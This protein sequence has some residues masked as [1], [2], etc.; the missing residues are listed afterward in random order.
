MKTCSPAT[1][2][3]TGEKRFLRPR[4]RVRAQLDLWNEKVGE[5][6]LFLSLLLAYW[7]AQAWFFVYGVKYELSLQL[8]ADWSRYTLIVG[9]G[10]GYVATFNALLLPITANRTLTNILYRLPLYDIFSVARWLPELHS[11]IAR[12]FTM[13][14][15]LHGIALSIAYGV[16]AIPFEGG[17]FS[18]SN[19]IPSTMVF[20][21]GC[22]LMAFL[23]A[24]V[25]LSLEAVRRRVYRVF[26]AS[27]MPLAIL[28][29]V[30]LIFHGLRG[31]RPWSAYFFGLPLILYIVD[32]VYHA[33]AAAFT[34][35]R[36]L[37]VRMSHENSNVV[38][39]EIERRGRKFVAG[40][41]FKLAWKSSLGARLSVA[42]EWHPFTVASSPSFDKDHMIFF[43]AATGSWT[44]ALR[45][46]ALQQG[47][48]QRERLDFEGP[49][50]L[51][52]NQQEKED[53]EGVTGTKRSNITI[54]LPSNRQW[55]LMAGPYGAPAQSH[56]NFAHQLLIGA[57]VGATPMVSIVQELCT[58][59]A[60]GPNTLSAEKTIAL[61]ADKDLESGL[62]NETAD[63]K[64]STRSSSDLSAF[65]EAKKLAINPCGGVHVRRSSA[66]LPPIVLARMGTIRGDTF[67][68][69]FS[70]VVLSNLW[71]FSILWICLAD[72]TLSI[73]AGAFSHIVAF[74]GSLSLFAV[75]VGMICLTVVADVRLSVNPPRWRYIFLP[76][77]MLLL[78]WFAVALT[79]A[80]LCSLLIAEYFLAYGDHMTRISKT[81]EW[82]FVLI[83]T[84]V[85][86]TLFV[87]LLFFFF[88][89]RSWTW[90]STPGA[91]FFKRRLTRSDPR[92][93][94]SA[95]KV[96]RDSVQ[97]AF[98]RVRTVTFVWVVRYVQDLWFLDKLYEL[99]SHQCD[100]SSHQPRLRMHVHI[101]RTQMDTS[102]GAT[103]E[104]PSDFGHVLQFHRGR[105]DFNEYMAELMNEDAENANA[106]EARAK[107]EAGGL[108]R[109][110]RTR[111]FSNK[112]HHGV[113]LCGSSS[114]ARS[115]RQSIRN[116]A[117]ERSAEGLPRRNVFFMKENF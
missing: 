43:I 22:A 106:E 36:V 94:E 70:A 39:L 45:A 115:V 72:L 76:R 88:L 73:C 86:I 26:W 19:R 116:V 6:G 8:P 5:S 97:A 89:P 17:F 34:P 67:L 108:A 100:H 21:T 102:T 50:H 65:E 98:S 95:H 46:L 52:Q 112:V 55:I 42:G 48:P 18:Y 105:P 38:R 44:N 80:V 111:A 96:S 9:R 82:L 1:T 23:L 74:I 75:I 40:Q 53:R 61:T 54:K 10:F 2:S 30:A 113:F 47:A 20:I 62:V 101:T 15:W 64:S 59:F 56:Q 81:K 91:N 58:R 51:E 107:S 99:A 69:R 87:L 104:L 60:E 79:N 109:F 85:H 29:Y 84:P 77:G 66:A 12:W 92:K 16:G 35:H 14:G 63:G 41:Y 90:R 3:R 110:Q 28:T 27:H 13:A 78:L 57:G 32:R 114:I 31:G 37:S 93:D 24:I 25:L 83:V 71:L 103:D 11:I 33:F 117:A 4:G 68:D 7:C 49:Q